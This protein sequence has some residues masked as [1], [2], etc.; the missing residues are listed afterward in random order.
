MNGANWDSAN[1]GDPFATGGHGR[2]MK[3][4]A[5][6]PVIGAV[7]ADDVDET[8]RVSPGQVY[9]REPP[10][11]PIPVAAA[12]EKKSWFSRLFSSRPSR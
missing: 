2:F 9:D 7:A 3:D 8:V 1:D 4:G 5:S 11:S 12:E 6:P 10:T